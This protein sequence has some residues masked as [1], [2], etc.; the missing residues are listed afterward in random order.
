MCPKIYPKCYHNKHLFFKQ[1][2]LTVAL[3]CLVSLLKQVNSQQPKL[4]KKKVTQMQRQ[5]NCQQV[6]PCS[7]A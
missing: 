1:P 7:S 2:Y 5:S 6:L 4:I 3:P